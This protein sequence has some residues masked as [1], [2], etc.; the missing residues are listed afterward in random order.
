MLSYDEILSELERK[1]N[2][3]KTELEEK[4]KNKYEELSGLV[5]L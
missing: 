2:I 1:T 5:S 4:I 3:A